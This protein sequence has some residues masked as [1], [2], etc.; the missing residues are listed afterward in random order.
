MF[1]KLSPQKVQHSSGYIVQTG[2]RYSLEYLDGQ[3]LAEVQADF[4][5]LTGLYPDSLMVR[6]QKDG[7]PRPPTSEERNTIMSRIEAALQFLGE[8]YEICRGTI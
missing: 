4:A 3:L 1:T 6:D 8:K 7:E 5:P 2:G